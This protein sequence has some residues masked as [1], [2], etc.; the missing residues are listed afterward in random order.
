MLNHI[1]NNYICISISYKR[2]PVSIIERA[3][4][5]DTRIGLLKLKKHEFIN[6][7]V[8]LQTCN[9]VEA[10][11]YSERPELAS[12]SV[13]NT[14]KEKCSDFRLDQ[15]VKVFYGDDAVKHLFEV[16]TS[17]DSMIIGENEILG[18]VNK[19]FLEALKS[20]TVG[21]YLRVLFEKALAVGKRARRETRI[22]KGAVSILHAAVDL[23]EEASDLKHAKILVIGAGT[24][25]R[26]LVK[27]LRDHGAEN[28]LILNRTL[29]KA[30]KLAEEHN[31]NAAPLYELNKHLKESDIV[32]VVTSA[33]KYIIRVE[34][35][36][37]I[38]HKLL[39]FD[40]STPR[41]V[42]IRVYNLSNIELK[43]IDDL[44]IIA[45]EN[46]RRR[47]EE[48]HRVKDLIRE[49]LESFKASLKIHIAEEIMKNIFLR[50]EKIR[51]KELERAIK[52]LNC[53]KNVEEVLEAMTK[54]IVKKVLSPM[55]EKIKNAALNG[56]FDTLKSISEIFSEG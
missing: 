42:D 20:K 34:D 48:I 4:F 50:A 2:A 54:S 45:E 46:K 39:I 32:F 1:L 23:A 13:I 53:D 10:Y 7:V 26:L 56:K 24:A 43:T 55:V 33:P 8:L 17:L 25:G 27:S 18:Q 19:A 16:S 6:E 35:L 49:E 37:S 52:I 21:P 41:N 9:R 14:F 30:I 40:L 31:Y 29:E 28:V 38:S 44:R 3:F 47:L 5:K 22:S 11:V 15:Y 36:D 51:R 12:A